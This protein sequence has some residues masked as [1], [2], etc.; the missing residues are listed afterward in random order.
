[1]KMWKRATC[2]DLA[3]EKENKEEESCTTAIADKP[4]VADPEPTVSAAN[5]KEGGEPG[6]S[7]KAG[8]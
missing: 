2:W 6:V 3:Q 4:A 5:I 1:M 8:T 7:K